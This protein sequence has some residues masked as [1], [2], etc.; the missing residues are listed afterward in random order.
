MFIIHGGHDQL[1]PLRQS[2]RLCNAFNGNPESGPASIIESNHKIQ[3]RQ[4]FSCDTRDSQLHVIT[5]AD[6][7]LDVCL[8]S[9]LC[10]AGDQES[11]NLARDSL[12]KGYQW[13]RQ[14]NPKVKSDSN[15]KMTENS[16]EMN[17]KKTGG[18]SLNIWWLLSL[19]YLS[20]GLKSMTTRYKKC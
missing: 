15:E 1:V 20:L 6:H 13:L 11:Q 9:I 7:T 10:P 14:N 12:Q 18:G 4:I 2:Q 16:G 8:F 3:K 19:S 5:E 17:N